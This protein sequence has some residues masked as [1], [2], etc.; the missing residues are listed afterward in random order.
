MGY[1]EGKN[2]PTLNRQRVQVAGIDIGSSAL[3]VCLF[4]FQP[5]PK[6]VENWSLPCPLLRPQPNRV[7]HN[8]AKI[9]Q[10]LNALLGKVPPDCRLGFG[11]AMHGLVMLDPDD[12]PLGDCLSWADGRSAFQAARLK[13]EDPDAH[14][15]TG[16][17]IHPMAWPSKIMWASEVHSSLWNRVKRLTDLKSYLIERLTGERYPMDISSASATGLWNHHESMWDPALLQRLKLQPSHLPEVSLERFSAEWKGHR[18]FPGAGDGPLANLGVGAVTS[19]R[20][21]V[22]LGTSGAM[23]QME[24]GQ[25]PFKSSLFRY[26]LDKDNWVRGGAITNGTLVLDWLKLQTGETVEE[27]LRKAGTIAPGADGLRVYPYFS[28]ERAPF[29]QPDVKSHISGWSFQHNFRHLS[30][31]AIEGVA[32]CL[33]RLLEELEPTNQP[34]RCT[35]GFFASPYWRQLLANV[36]G[37]SVAMGPSYEASALGAALMATDDYL[38]VSAALPVGELT[39]PEDHMV[40]VYSEIYEEWLAGEPTHT[41]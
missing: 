27:I 22:S 26:A 6:M 23:R 12:Q 28:G 29:W 14:R 5:E 30:C 13:N 21:A 18:L 40:Q 35:G 37:H 31:A 15:R 16:T 11:S 2:S 17:P 7:E 20:V 3:K 36:T 41:S 38:S 9:E 25:N 24:T 39:E 32:F 10:C 4:E 1:F 33:R 8:L 19:G 34:L